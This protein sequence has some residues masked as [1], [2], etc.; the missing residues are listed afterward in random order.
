[1]EASSRSLAIAN[2]GQVPVQFE[3]IHKPSEESYCKPWLIAE[4]FKGFIMPGEKCEVNLRINVDKTT[5]SLLNAGKDKL[6][7]ILVLHLLGGKDIFITVSGNY[8]KS[9]FGCSIEA[10]VHLTVPITELSPGQ[11]VSLENGDKEKLPLDKTDGAKEPYPVPKELWFLCDVMTT[12]GL[13]HQ[14]LF[15]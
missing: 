9:C 2:T 6:Y 14:N 10:L 12:L 8:E 11:I 5:A 4:P 3:F 7:D 15:L 13:S 1:M